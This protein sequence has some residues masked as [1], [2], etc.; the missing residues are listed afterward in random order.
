MSASP[1]FQSAVEA[2]R[3]NWAFEDFDRAAA[4]MRQLGFAVILIPTSYHGPMSVYEVE[5]F[6]R[7]AVKRCIAER[8]A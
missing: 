8:L 1:Q 2:L 7:D 5:D 4:R 6:A 3:L